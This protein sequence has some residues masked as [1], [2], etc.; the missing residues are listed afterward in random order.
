MKN[1]LLICA[2]FLPLSSFAQTI[3][4]KAGLALA[5][6][7]AVSNRA[8]NPTVP[9]S[10]ISTTY[11]TGYTLGGNADFRMA[12]KLFLRTGVEM[13]IKG[14]KESGI[15]TFNGT[16]Y[17]YTDRNKFVGFDFP[18]QLI[19]TTKGAGA[20]HWMLGGGPVPGF[21]FEGGLSRRDLGLG[22]LAGYALPSG[23]N[24]NVTYNH[25]LVNVATRSFD[26]KSLKNRHLG[27]T[28]GYS[29]RQKTIAERDELKT[30]REQ[31]PTDLLAERALYAELGGPGGFLSFNYDIRF[32]KS[33]KGMGIRAGIGT[34]FDPYNVG[35]TIPVA[36][37]CLL[38]EKAHFFELAAGTSFYHFKEKNQDG[39]F[40]FS[41]PS[42]LA[43]FAW[44]GYRYQPVERKFVFRA[45]F[46]QF[47]GIRM[48]GYQRFPYPSLS[49]GYSLK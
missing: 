8:T 36:L 41:K 1:F 12:E 48:S 4:V 14:G 6:Y 26:Y 34:L 3:S 24:A 29:F 7:S 10:D 21:L 31:A 37:N 32:T 22:I 38:G 2:I 19:Y 35:V 45:G 23:L 16:S 30:A 18:I 43:P 28:I 49:F 15:Y 42:F 20:P 47:I 33:N 46:T 27:L 13:V 5:T 11:R 40:N 17:P 44:V 39:W 25:G 9:T